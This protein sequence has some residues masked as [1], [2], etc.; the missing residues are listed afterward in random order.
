MAVAVR[1]V[2]TGSAEEGARVVAPM[3]EVATPV[4]GGFG[5][6]PYAAIGSVHADPVDPM[7]VTE[8]ALLLSG[9]D[10]VAVESLIEVA[11]PESGSPQF[12][13]E[14]RQLGGAVARRPER[15]DALSHRDAAYAL[16]T[17]GIGV[18]PLV[19]T[20]EEHAAAVAEAM[21][22]WTTGG[23]FPN[24]GGPV[25]AES[26]AHIYDPATLS[27]L[28]SLAATYDPRGV[29]AGAAALM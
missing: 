28:T 14:L 24:F 5:V 27:R 17:I 8:S 26:R 21:L 23:G 6:L 12:L 19:G 13:V 25:T 10:A 7:P 29:L 22:P 16:L 9:L 15:G 1:F 20:V 3:L 11:G 2:W 4:L 18:P